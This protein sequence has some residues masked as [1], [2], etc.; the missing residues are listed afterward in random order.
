MDEM[1]KKND[2]PPYNTFC[3]VDEKQKDNLFSLSI[4]ITV[5]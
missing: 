4:P 2:E 3:P 1:L 5:T